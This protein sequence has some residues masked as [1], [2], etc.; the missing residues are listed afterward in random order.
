MKKEKDRK[1]VSHFIK[2]A[3]ASSRMISGRSK[4]STSPEE[5]KTDKFHSTQSD[6]KIP[7]KKN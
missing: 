7:E 6:N 1:K 2:T 3:K 4:V 5:K